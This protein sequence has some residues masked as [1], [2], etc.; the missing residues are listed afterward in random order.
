MERMQLVH[1]YRPGD[2]RVDDVPCPP[3]ALARSQA[4]VA[5]VIP[6]FEGAA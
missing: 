1:I 6:A 3:P 4:E 2:V 5:K